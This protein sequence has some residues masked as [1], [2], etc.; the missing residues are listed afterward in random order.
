MA[1]RCFF[2]DEERVGD[3]IDAIYA[4]TPEVFDG[5]LSEG[6]LQL[7]E[8]VMRHL[9]DRDDAN[10]GEV[11]VFMGLTLKETA[12]V[13]LW[14]ADQV[15]RQSSGAFRCVAVAGLSSVGALSHIPTSP[16]LH[17]ASAAKRSSRP[18]S[19]GP[20]RDWRSSARRARRATRRRRSPRNCSA[21][22]TR[23][24]R[25]SW[26]RRPQ[27]SRSRTRRS[28]GPGNGGA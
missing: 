12:Y 21:S 15:E 20:T 17:L 1:S 24:A 25:S 4:M 19:R 13:Y 23:S 16:A 22:W 5:L 11:E 8:N 7:P 14:K 2:G 10:R 26:R 9:L 27:S 18:S 6:L 28:R 3:V